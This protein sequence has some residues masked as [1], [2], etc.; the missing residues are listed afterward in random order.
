MN[1]ST[2]GA[3]SLYWYFLKKALHGGWGWVGGIST[4]LGIFGTIMTAVWPESN[5]VLVLLS[6]LIPFAVLAICVIVGP[7]VVV[8]RAYQEKEREL[9]RIKQPAVTSP[10]QELIDKTDW[11]YQS[12]SGVG[13]PEVAQTLAEEFRKFVATIQNY[14]LASRASRL[15]LDNLERIRKEFENTALEHPSQI[16]SFVSLR[17]V[18]PIRDI[19]VRWKQ[20]ESE[21]TS[22]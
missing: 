15:D 5:V 7:L 10:I 16:A 8:L 6:A 14:A 20:K 2:A 12:C 22:S 1:D 18:H 17:F 4:V 19:L 21:K 3:L 13:E 11:F 9:A